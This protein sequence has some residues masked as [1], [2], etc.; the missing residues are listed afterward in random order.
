MAFRK[1]ALQAIGGFDP[2][3]RVAGDDVDVC[4]RL[5]QRGWTL[6]FNPSAVVWHHRRN[7]VKAYWKQQ[8]GYGKAEALLERKWPSKYNAAGHVAWAG[9]I[10]GR[11]IAATIGGWRARIYQG[12]WG[13]APFQS[14]YE[15]A[16]GT[17]SAW[18]LMPEW[19]LILLLLG[20]LSGLGALWRPLLFTLPLLALGAGAPVV[21]AVRNAA[22]V[23]LVDEGRSRRGRVGARAVM[24]FL[25]LLQPAARLRGRLRHGLAPWRHSGRRLLSPPWPRTS[26]IWRE[27]WEAPGTT[28]ER[29]EAM[30]LA[31]GV[32]VLRGGDFDRWDL[33]VRGGMLGGVHVRMAIEEHGAGRQLVRLRSWPRYARG[34]ILVS[35]GLAGLSGGAALDSAWA[36]SLAL[37]AMALVPIFYMT[38]ACAAA[39]AAV[40][41]AVRVMQAMSETREETAQLPVPSDHP[42]ALLAPPGGEEIGR[43]VEVIVQDERVSEIGP[44]TGVV[45]SAELAR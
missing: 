16:P 36:V 25:H 22:R 6:G 26:T 20:A 18:L 17:L 38:E 43:A 44:A 33:E 9:R 29:L 1:D 41:H 39:A 19:Y 10:Y 11:G 3:F 2:Q 7:S 21:N 31:D 30:L 24:A 45:P 5:Q 35:L 8:A 13:S 14:L 28:L 4:W 27:Q 12:T 34:A 37:G 32:P 15:R 40:H 42:P 23:R